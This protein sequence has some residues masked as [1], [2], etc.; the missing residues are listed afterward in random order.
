MAESGT[1]Y[2]PLPQEAP[3]DSKKTYETIFSQATGFREIPSDAWMAYLFTL[4]QDYPTILS[5]KKLE[6]AEREVY[7]RAVLS[8]L[9]WA[10][11]L[12]LQGGM[13]YWIA[14]MV[15]L[16]AVRSAQNLYASYRTISYNSAGQFDETRFQDLEDKSETCQIAMSSHIFLAAI[17][18]LW[19]SQMF[20]EL[21]QVYR[22]F[23]DLNSL[24]ALPAGLADEYMCQR[25][26]SGEGVFQQRKYV[27]CCLTNRTYYS[28][29]ACVT[30]PK[31]LVS[32]GLMIL[33][34]VWLTASESFADLILNAL[35]LEFVTGIDELMFLV[36]LPARLSS[37]LSDFFIAVPQLEEENEDADVAN[38]KEM[39]AAYKRSGVFLFL[40]LTYTIVFVIFQ[41]V[42]PRFAWDLQKGCE[43]YLAQVNVP[44][45]KPFEKGCF[46]FPEAGA[47]P[48]M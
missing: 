13:L 12:A 47:L 48:Q 22:R 31:V 35:A 41:P 45:C 7:Y 8:T 25:I 4:V 24:P 40:V 5:G 2:I 38:R 1:T 6:R 32:L 44:F 15:T 26:T 42:I 29:L 34:S 10:A 11:N 28:I 43:A 23:R 20:K 33:G 3:E 30:I 14:T 27:F 19:A 18:F 37:T 9:T 36:F 16:P 21:R 46:P 39:R 17:I